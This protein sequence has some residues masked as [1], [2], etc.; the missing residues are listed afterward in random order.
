MTEVEPIGTWDM[1]WYASRVLL[2]L[3]VVVPALYYALR[4][5]GRRLVVNRSI[6][7]NMEVIDI[8]PLGT[9]KQLLL[10][11]VAEEALLLGVTKDGIR[12]LWEAPPE[13]VLAAERPRERERHAAD[14]KKW[15][16]RWRKQED[17]Q[18]EG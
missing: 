9:G 1:M 4:H 8:L 16:D 14:L 6:H 7:G 15:V 13:A 10:V 2:A 12:F 18:D 3:V 11:K 17:G 5:W